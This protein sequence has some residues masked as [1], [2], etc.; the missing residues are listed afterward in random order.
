MLYYARIVEFISP[1]GWG[2]NKRGGAKPSYRKGLEGA[3]GGG[4]YKEGWV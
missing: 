1:R 4:M 2:F 3:G